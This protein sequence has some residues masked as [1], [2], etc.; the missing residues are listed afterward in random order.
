MRSFLPSLLTLLCL[1]ALLL[2]T[3]HAQEVGYVRL[4]TNAD[5][6]RLYVNGARADWQ[7]DA[8]LAFS[9]GPIHLLLLHGEADTWD[10]RSAAQTLQVVSGDT[11]DVRLDLPVRYRLDSMPYGAEVTHIGADGT[12]TSLGAT[13]LS[14]DRAEPLAGTLVIAKEGYAEQEL[15]PGAAFTNAQS[16]LLRPLRDQGGAEV[17]GLPPSRSNRWL[18]VA[19]GTLALAGA[20]TAVYFK[21]RADDIDDRYRDPFSPERGDPA[22]RSEAQR[23]D[24]YSAVG[25][26]AMQ[27]GIGV[28]AVRL[29]L[30]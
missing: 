3:V 30:R 12:A 20:A 14:F 15:V 7:A 4:A 16:V 29:V 27:V 21:L 24:T 17:V 8:P 22:L 6:A 1:S 28:L 10:A 26:G 18:D 2:P 13:P 23:L 5:D 19:A 11:L 9:P 25:L